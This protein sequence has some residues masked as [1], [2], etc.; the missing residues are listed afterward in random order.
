MNRCVSF[1]PSQSPSENSTKQLKKGIYSLQWE[2]RGGGMDLWTDE[3]F[4]KVPLKVE[5]WS[6]SHRAITKNEGW[7]RTSGAGGRGGERSHRSQWSPGGGGSS[8]EVGARCEKVAKWHPPCHRPQETEL[9]SMW[10]QQDASRTSSAGVSTPWPVEAGTSVASPPGSHSHGRWQLAHVPTCEQEWGWPRE[11]VGLCFLVLAPEGRVLRR[12]K[13]S[14][15]LLICGLI[16]R[17]E[18]FPGGSEGNASACNAGDLGSIPGLGRSPKEGNGNLLQDSCLE[19]PMD[20]EAW[21]AAVHGVPKSWTRQRDFTFTFLFIHRGTGNIWTG[22]HSSS[23]VQAAAWW[24]R[25]QQK[26]AERFPWA[27][28]RQISAQSRLCQP[29]T[30][31]SQASCL[32]SLRKSTVTRK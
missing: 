22:Q 4:Q 8:R 31:S 17:G 21:K 15:S 23:L 1:P 32:T 11:E 12:P 5:K 3:S 7:A 2:S 24:E 14:G 9:E 16:H 19:N 26:A 29:Y 20:G 10:Q 18:A 30:V 28:V 6:W 27:G 25:Q 13:P